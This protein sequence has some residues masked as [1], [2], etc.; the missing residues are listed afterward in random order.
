MVV[1]K[2]LKLAAHAGGHVPD[3][4]GENSL[5]CQFLIMLLVA[6]T[7]VVVNHAKNLPPLYSWMVG[8]QSVFFFCHAD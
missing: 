6:W 7:S 5:S 8:G 1:A 3:Y 4:E 2:E